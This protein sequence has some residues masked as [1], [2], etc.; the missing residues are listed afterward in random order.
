MK[1]ISYIK[2]LILAQHLKESVLSPEVV[3]PSNPK[4]KLLHNTAATRHARPRALPSAIT[5][6]V[7]VII[8]ILTRYSLYRT[9]T[10]F[11]FVRGN[12]PKYLSIKPN[13]K[14]RIT[15]KSNNLQKKN[16]YRQKCFRNLRKSIL[17]LMIEQIP[18]LSITA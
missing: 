17:N 5:V 3:V 12:N 14:N 1:L 7:I 18:K 16:F 9:Q 4:Q 8:S 2:L 11:L 13:R 6:I 10:L 15:S